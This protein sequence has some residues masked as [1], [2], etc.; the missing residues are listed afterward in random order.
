MFTVFAFSAL[1]QPKITYTMYLIFIVIIF[2]SKY[3]EQS[4][5]LKYMLL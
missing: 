2:M 3:I 4:E 5:S 1:M